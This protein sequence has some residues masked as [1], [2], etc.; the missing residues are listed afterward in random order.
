MGK[1]N[2]KAITSSKLEFKLIEKQEF[3]TAKQGRQIEGVPSR[4]FLSSN[5]F[6][7]GYGFSRCQ[8]VVLYDSLDRKG[9]L[10][11]NHP[12]ETPSYI[13][14]GE[15]PELGKTINP[16]KEF[17]DLGRVLAFH[18]YHESDYIYPESWIEKPLNEIGIKQVEH[19]SVRCAKPGFHQ[20]MDVG[21]DV[22]K[23]LLYIIPTDFDNGIRLKI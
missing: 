20:W 12:S 3:E 21:F 17:E 13:I 19:I 23:G 9:A 16:K 1:T 5:D 22:K 2:I 7:L 6:L 18:V 14:Q 10:L 11:H 4:F 8:A 15:Y